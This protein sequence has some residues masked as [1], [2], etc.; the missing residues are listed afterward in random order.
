LDQTLLAFMQRTQM[1]IAVLQQ[2]RLFSSCLN[3]AVTLHHRYLD[4][5]LVDSTASAISVLK[6]FRYH[7]SSIVNHHWFQEPR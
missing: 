5:T 7:K 6:Y 2:R 4:D 3:Y 1:S